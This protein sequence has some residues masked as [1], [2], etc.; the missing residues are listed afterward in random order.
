MPSNYGSMRLMLRNCIN[1]LASSPVSPFPVSATGGSQ[2]LSR[3]RKTST[4]GP[5]P[6]SFVAAGMSMLSSLGAGW[7]G[8]MA[9]TAIV[10]NFRL[11]KTRPGH[12][13]V[14]CGHPEKPSRRGIIDTR[15]TRKVRVRRSS[16][17]DCPFPETAVA[18]A[19]A[20][21]CA[22]VGKRSTICDGAA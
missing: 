2:V 3:L 16:P 12:I 8:T 9:S 17:I 13:D 14:A 10:G 5:W 22:L 11:S 1:P 19:I 21:R 4:T 6:G 18:N 20:V 7:P 15:M